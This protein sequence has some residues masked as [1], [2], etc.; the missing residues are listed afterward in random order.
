MFSHSGL[1]ALADGRRRLALHVADGF[2]DTRGVR[3]RPA[4]EDAG[5]VV[6]EDLEDGREPWV[7][8]REDVM[9]APVE[10][11]REA[12]GELLVQP[13]AV[14]QG[15]MAAERVAGLILAVARALDERPPL[16]VFALAAI[17]PDAPVGDQPE[18][19]FCS[20]VVE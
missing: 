12:L 19:F 15:A 18:L 11:E 16:S 7:R 14:R 1:Q 5:L 10:R 3:V 4:R 8:L 13:T 9:R 20:G 17:I 2:D 6:A